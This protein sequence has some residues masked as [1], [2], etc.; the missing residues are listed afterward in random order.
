V[1]I[2]IEGQRDEGNG[3]LG[4]AKETNCTGMCISNQ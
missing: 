3:S 4:E 2:D 1:I